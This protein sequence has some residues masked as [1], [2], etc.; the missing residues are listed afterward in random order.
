MEIKFQV[1]IMQ[2][3]FVLL[4][5]HLL[6]LARLSNNKQVNRLEANSSPTCAKLSNIKVKFHHVLQVSK[7]NKKVRTWNTQ[8]DWV[9]YYNDLRGSPESLR[10]KRQTGVCFVASSTSK[11][12][13]V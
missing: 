2:R 11:D 1:I 7:T 5:L 12:T 9:S 13:A 3:A 8:V 6:T 4:A 10:E